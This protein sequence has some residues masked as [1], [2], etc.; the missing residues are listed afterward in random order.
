MASPS[1]MRRMRIEDSSSKNDTIMRRKDLRGAQE[2]IGAEVLMRSL[3]VWRLS[4]RK[5]DASWRLV[6]MRVFEGGVGWVRGGMLERSMDM[7]LFRE[8]RDV[9]RDSGGD[10]VVGESVGESSGD[11]ILQVFIWSR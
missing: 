7:L 4:A 3:I 8:L 5:M 2:W 9:G 1:K 6:I 11:A 10:V